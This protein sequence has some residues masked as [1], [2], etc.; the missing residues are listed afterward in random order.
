[1]TTTPKARCGVSITGIGSFLPPSSISN[2]QLETLVD[3]NDEWIVSRTG[4]KNRRVVSGNDTVADLAIA[5]AK[6]AL[7]CAGIEGK[8]VDLVIVTTSTADTIYPMVCAL[9]QE[10][11]GATSAAGFDLALAC[12]GFV[13]GLVTAQ[14]FIENGR[15]QTVLVVSADIHSRETDWSDRNTCVLFGDG[16]GACV[17][18]ANTTG[19]SDIVAS[20][21]R[22]DGS[23]GQ[24]L[25]LGTLTQNCPLVA[26]RTNQNPYV[27]MNG[28]E[29]FKFAV[30]SVPKSIQV[31][32]DKAS[33]TLDD[34]DFVV[35]HQANS[36]I[37]Q[38]MAEKMGLPE[39]KL[40]IRFENYGNT[41]AASIPIA[42]NDAVKDGQIQAGQRLMLCGYGAGLAW[43]TAL[44]NWH[45]VDHRS[46]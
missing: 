18:Q 2:A 26:P 29:V 46:H 3:T 6:D 8:Q 42:L 20:D 23:R 12:T 32:L 38:A 1:M 19:Q 24:F 17:L 40:I 15:Y 7:A 34:V 31:T 21:L 37:M 22:V 27:Q 4:I 9:V 39:A 10:A 33:V 5:A 30:G 28:R 45:V 44:V 14:Q 43:A 25:T 11:I 16:A 13:Y 36:R 41:S 35:L